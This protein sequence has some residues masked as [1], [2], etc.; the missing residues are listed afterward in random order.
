MKKLAGV[1]DRLPIQLDGLGP[2][3]L[4]DMDE[5]LRTV[6]GRGVTG[7]VCQITLDELHAGRLQRRTL[8]LVTD[9][10]LDVMTSLLEPQAD[11]V[12]DVS[13]AACH[14]HLHRG[15]SVG[16]RR[17]STLARARRQAPSGGS[18]SSLPVGRTSV[19]LDNCLRTATASAQQNRLR[20]VLDSHERITHVPVMFHFRDVTRRVTFRPPVCY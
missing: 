19:R 2:V 6:R 17:F 4:R 13:R 8:L 16:W 7:R 20:C 5:C 1:R 12:S 18:R 3:V 11:G 14:E 15:A 10:R 9:E